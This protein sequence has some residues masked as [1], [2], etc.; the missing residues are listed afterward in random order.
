MAN[1]KSLRTLARFRDCEAV[2]DKALEHPGLLYRLP[3]SGEAIQF[4]QRCNT[5]RKQL[6]EQ[7]VSIGDGEIVPVGET[8][9]DVLVIRQVLADGT[10]ARE[11]TFIRF[12]HHVNSLGEMILPTGEAEQLTLD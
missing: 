11:G 10:S 1:S 3:T 5:Y 8:A 4:K 6:R 9:Y 2:M 12:D 7:S